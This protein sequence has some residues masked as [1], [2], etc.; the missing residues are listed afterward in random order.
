T[1]A[2]QE[3]II[4]FSLIGALNRNATR[5]PPII[6]DTPLG[7]LGVKHKTNVMKHLADFG[8]QVI[9]LVHDDEVSEDILNSV[10]ADIV[11]E[12]ELERNDLFRT[13]IRKRA[14]L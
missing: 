11:A 12:Y 2:G 8:D 13:S 3:Q 7:R 1:S 9:L 4:A 6:M 5:R 14:A 10:R